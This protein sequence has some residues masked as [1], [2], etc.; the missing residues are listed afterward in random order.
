MICCE[1]CGQQ[2]SS[3]TNDYN[4]YYTIRMSY[5]GYRIDNPLNKSYIFDLC[6]KCTGEL[7]EFVKNGK[8]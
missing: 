4:D 7:L 8:Q 3:L 6:P 1:K 2:V 5:N